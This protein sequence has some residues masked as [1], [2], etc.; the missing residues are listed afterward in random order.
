M[1]AFRRASRPAVDGGFTGSHNPLQPRSRGLPYF[2]LS[3]HHHAPKVTMSKNYCSEINLHFVWHTKLSIPLLTPQI[4]SITH[5][6]IRQRLINTPGVFF[7]EIGGT[8]NHVHTVIT[9]APTILI[10][11][12]IGKTKGSSSHEINQRMG[13]GKKILEWQPG[14]G[15]VTFGTRDLD[16]FQEYVRNQREHH[17]RGTIQDRLERTM[18]DDAQ[19]AQAIAEQAP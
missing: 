12:L 13:N 17:S 14:Y 15:V 11:D 19:K 18:S 3:H 6:F 4:E 5:Q 10:S 7:H 9:V 16:W 8:E 2:G 1:G